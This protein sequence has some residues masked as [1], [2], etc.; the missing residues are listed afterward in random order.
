MINEKLSHNLLLFAYYTI[1]FVQG[2]LLLH[3]LLLLIFIY[4]Y[5][6]GKIFGF[7]TNAPFSSKPPTPSPRGGNFEA[8]NKG[9]F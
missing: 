6:R 5:V 2:F 7:G 4:M 1:I 3:S 8:G 9:L